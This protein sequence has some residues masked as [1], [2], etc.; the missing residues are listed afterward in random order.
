[1]LFKLKINVW[2]HSRNIGRP[3]SRLAPNSLQI[4]FSTT[5]N[6]SVVPDAGYRFSHWFQYMIISPWQMF[7]TQNMRQLTTLLGRIRK[8][9]CNVIKSIIAK[10]RPCWPFFAAVDGRHFLIGS[11]RHVGS[12]H[13][14]RGAAICSSKQLIVS[15][16]NIK[17][18][19][20]A[21]WTKVAWKTRVILQMYF[22]KHKGGKNERST[23]LKSSHVKALDRTPTDCLTSQSHQENHVMIKCRRKC[24]F[25]NRVVIEFNHQ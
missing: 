23:K 11:G 24:T 18:L 17:R 9:R 1:M 20:T 13:N 15:I 12:K 7:R 10:L 22:D 5:L 2:S 21:L 16:F 19:S 4:L 3:M 6:I 8:T 14:K 25:N